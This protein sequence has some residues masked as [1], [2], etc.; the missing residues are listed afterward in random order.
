MKLVDNWKQIMTGAWS[1]HLMVLAAVVSSLPVLVD[2]I[3]A[4]MLG[5]NPFV[6]AG[7]AVVI[8]VV[9]ILAR[10][11]VQPGADFFSDESGAVRLRKRTVGGAAA[12]CIA[13][14]AF[15]GPWEELRTKA[16]PDAL[17]RN[18]PTVC[19][20]ETRG[21]KLG[22]VYTKLECHNMLAKAVKQFH[23]GLRRCLPE[24]DNI[25]IGAQVAF[26]SWSYNVGTG[27]ACRSTLVRKANAGDLMGACNQLPRWNRASGLVIKGLSNRR[28]AERALCLEA[29]G[30]T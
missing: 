29:L 25:P 13:A 9:A 20:G 8:N 2:L 5:I 19:Y 4:E 30:A 28:G 26:T 14:A 10:I 1:V 12:V 21:V 18:I 17:A 16:Y 7:V 11:L 23:D 22:D 3:S 24:L 6:F 27:A 15:I